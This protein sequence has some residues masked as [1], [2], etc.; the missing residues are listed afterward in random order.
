[1]IYNDIIFSDSLKNAEIEYF[2][3]YNISSR[4]LMENAS[5]ALFSV[6]FEYIREDSKICFVCGSGNNGGDG[7]ACACLLSGVGVDGLMGTW[8]RV[9]NN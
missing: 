3:E 5:N 4:V 1:M 8:G 6:L 2:N 7:Y 9:N